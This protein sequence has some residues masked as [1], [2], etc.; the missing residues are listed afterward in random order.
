LRQ[1]A[2]RRS[3]VKK[4]WNVLL[5]TAAAVTI[6]T[7][8]SAATLSVLAEAPGGGNDFAGNMAA[9]WGAGNVGYGVLSSVSA[10]TN[11]ILTFTRW[12]S[13][14]GYVNTF[15]ATNGIDTESFDESA[16]PW[17]CGYMSTCGDSEQREFMMSFTGTLAPDAFRFSSNNGAPAVIG[18]TGM[19]LYYDL[20]GSSMYAFLAYDDDGAGPDDN[21]DDFLVKVRA[22]D[23][24][25]TAVPLPAA[26]WLFLSAL[27]GIVALGRKKAAS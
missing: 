26:G 25:V 14:S 7:G 1:R 23:L 18:E 22:R 5:A 12:G 4:T 3:K 27:G 21:H 19:G 2:L 6:S 13:E 24:T 11:E 20:T 9:L 16:D 10:G 15:T 17:A 8:A